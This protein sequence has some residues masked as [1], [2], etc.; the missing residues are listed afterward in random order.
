MPGLSVLA[1]LFYYLSSTQLIYSLVAESLCESKNLLHWWKQRE[2]LGRTLRPGRVIEK[3]RLQK[4]VP[5]P[6]GSQA[7]IGLVTAAFFGEVHQKADCPSR[8]S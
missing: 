2:N 4:T 5:R 3:D 7:A 8:M 6:P 1:M